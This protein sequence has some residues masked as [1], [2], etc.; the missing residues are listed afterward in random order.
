MIMLLLAVSN[1]SNKTRI[2]NYNC[3][4]SYKFLKNKN[5]I[6]KIILWKLYLFTVPKCYDC[7]S[8]CINDY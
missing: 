4:V 1:I 5:I 3:F 6:F 8:N 7:A 2:C